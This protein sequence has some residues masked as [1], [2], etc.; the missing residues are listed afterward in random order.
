MND[1]FIDEKQITRMRLAD[2]VLA[3]IDAD[4]S[5]PPLDEVVAILDYASRNAQGRDAAARYAGLSG[6]SGM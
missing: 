5:H 4:I 1:E 2:Q 6:P 3:V